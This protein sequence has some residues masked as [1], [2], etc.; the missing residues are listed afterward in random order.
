MAAII[1][2]FG[3]VL[4]LGLALGG[5]A[6]SQPA[7]TPKSEPRVHC[8]TGFVFP[9]EAGGLFLPSA[10]QPDAK[11]CVKRV[12]YKKLYLRSR[13]LISIEPGGNAPCAE[14]FAREDAQ[15]RELSPFL[16]PDPDVRPLRLLSQSVQQHTA[17]YIEP[18]SHLG[19]DRS[20]EA[21]QTLWIGCIGPNDGETATW[22][23]RYLEYYDATDEA[24]VAGLA[25]K[26][27]AAIDWSP[28]VGS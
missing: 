11:G 22:F 24:E 17:R 28:L 14:L 16:K 13:L 27:F 12:S 25:E 26:L 6:R 19:R 2:H 9:A 8:G 21:R 18:E 23:I 4:A 15:K 20:P 5:P 7:E 1:R 3:A 10:T